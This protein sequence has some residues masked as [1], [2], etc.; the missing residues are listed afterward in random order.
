MLVEEF[1]LQLRPKSVME[2]RWN[3]EIVANEWLVKWKGLPDSEAT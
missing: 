2:V 3:E 1:E